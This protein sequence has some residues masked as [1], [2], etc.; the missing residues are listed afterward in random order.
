MVAPAGGGRCAIGPWRSRPIR[1]VPQARIHISELGPHPV[2]LG[3]ELSTGNTDTPSL[4]TPAPPTTSSPKTSGRRV[5]R[6]LDPSVIKQSWI[7]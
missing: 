1:E 7:G 5:S 2:H 4:C 3:L 6:N